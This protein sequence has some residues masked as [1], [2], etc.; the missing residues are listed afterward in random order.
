[1]GRIQSE[2]ANFA[3][4]SLRSIESS[5]VLALSITIPCSVHKN[6]SNTLMTALEYRCVEYVNNEKLNETVDF[7]WHDVE[8]LNPKHSSS[9]IVDSGDKL[10]ILLQ[11]AAMFYFTPMGLKWT[12]T[13]LFLLYLL[14]VAYFVYL[15]VYPYMEVSVFEGLMWIFNLGFIVYELQEM[16]DGGVASYFNYATSG[17]LNLFDFLI[18]INWIIIFIVRCIVGSEHHDDPVT[19][20]YMVLWCIQCVLLSIRTLTLFKTSKHLGVFLRML[21]L[22]FMD[23]CK[24]AAVLTIIFIGFLFGVW[25]IVADDYVDSDVP[26]PLDDVKGTALYLFQTLVGQQEWEV[27][28]QM[29]IMI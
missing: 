2:N 1:M 8:F 3:S 14:W 4:D 15:Q 21:Q 13:V 6:Q 7:M 19:V 29:V 28:Q 9:Y 24:F 10:R 12:T 26:Q 17:Y 22:M 5:A 23:V 27:V 18:S 20:T 11:S 16:I 25:M